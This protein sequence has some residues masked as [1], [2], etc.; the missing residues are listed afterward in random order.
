MFGP[1][2]ATRWKRFSWAVGLA[3]ALSP[4]L[5]AED[6]EATLEWIDL[7]T[8]A[9]TPLIDPLTGELLRFAEAAPAYDA[10]LSLLAEAPIPVVR[11]PAAQQLW[12][13]QAVSAGNRPI[14]CAR[15][16][17]GP[18]RILIIGSLWGN[19]PEAI[20]LLDATAQLA[21]QV[22]TPDSLAILI[23]R[24]LNPDALAEHMQTNAHGVDLFRSF[25]SSRSVVPVRAA[26]TP[27]QL[28]PEVQY[29]VNVLRESRPQ[30]VI[31][32]RS[33]VGEHPLITV[34]SHWSE[35]SFQGVI[36]ETIR[37]ARFEG[38]LKA[39]SLDEFVTRDVQ[40]PFATVHLPPGN[41]QS[42]QPRDLL[43]F[44]S[45]HIPAP[46]AASESKAPPAESTAVKKPAELS[47]KLERSTPQ[48]EAPVPVRDGEKGVVTFLP[49]PP[50]LAS[51]SSASS[52][53]QNDRYF[54]LPPPRR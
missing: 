22:R 53:V 1:R 25:P 6:L 16:G 40:L 17:S 12:T 23:I 45:A 5:R 38:E 37:V 10:P 26:A 11:K 2:F 8:A 52:D 29:L 15:F 47:H 9:S 43:R 13:S 7:P 19:D 32:V 46:N 33:S 49:P 4:T 41:S 31:H 30:H 18:K 39:G 14:E 20:Q 50:E 36:P 51:T 54:E 21:S 48:P 42:L 24:T 44:A 3:F 28:E 35:K 27:T 34:N